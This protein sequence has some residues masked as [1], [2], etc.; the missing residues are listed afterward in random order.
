[1]DGA[2]GGFHLGDGFA[3]TCHILFGVERIDR[4]LER[5]TLLPGHLLRQHRDGRGHGHSKLIADVVETVF[6]IVIHPDAYRSLR[7]NITLLCAKYNTL[8][9]HCQ[10]IFCEH[11]ARLQSAR[12]AISRGNAVCKAGCYETVDGEH[13]AFRGFWLWAGAI[14]GEFTKSLLRLYTH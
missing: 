3:Q 1:M 4:K 13:R 14:H 6:Q 11:A 2:A 7:H 12:N 9:E 10:Q 5:Q 8:Y